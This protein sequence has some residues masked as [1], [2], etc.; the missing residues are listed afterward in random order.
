M[1]DFYTDMGDFVRNILGATS[2]GGL[3]QGEIALKRITKVTPDPTKPWEPVFPQ[4]T[5]QKL[6]GAVKGIDAK[7]VGVEVGGTVLLATDR[8]AI[9]EVPSIEYQAGDILSIDGFDVNVIAVKPIPAAGIRSAVKF[10]IR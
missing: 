9:T 8:E 3:G 5:T 1:S 10:Y 7:M 6:R 4:V 2:E